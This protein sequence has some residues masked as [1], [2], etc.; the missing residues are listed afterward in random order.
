MAHTNS[1]MLFS[2][3]VLAHATV[4]R[5]NPEDILAGKVRKS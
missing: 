5:T 3:A 1:R 2:K 4:W